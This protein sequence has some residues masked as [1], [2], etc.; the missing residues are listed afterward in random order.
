MGGK[1]VP[2][3]HICNAWDK[4]NKMKTTTTQLKMG[5]NG[6]HRQK[7]CMPFFTRPTTMLPNVRD[8]HDLKKRASKI[9][10][11]AIRGGGKENVV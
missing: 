10:H 3:I 1:D 8:Q 5:P 4:C 7:R 9:S 2:K 6:T 11:T